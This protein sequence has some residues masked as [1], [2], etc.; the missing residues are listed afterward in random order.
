LAT[1]RPARKTLLPPVRTHGLYGAADRTTASAH[2]ATSPPAFDQAGTVEDRVVLCDCLTR[3]GQL[4][5]ERGGC[6]FAVGEKD[7]E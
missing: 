3:D 2:L 1:V 4:P 7:V 6:R 5:R